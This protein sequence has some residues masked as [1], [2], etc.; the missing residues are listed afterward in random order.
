MSPDVSVVRT[1]N[2][3]VDASVRIRMELQLLVDCFKKLIRLS[4]HV[5]SPLGDSLLIW[6]DHVILP[7]LAEK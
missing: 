7:G 1:H 5:C 3:S 2:L 4:N 6:A